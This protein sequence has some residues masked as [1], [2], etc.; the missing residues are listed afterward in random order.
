MMSFPLILLGVLVEW[1][2]RASV[3][4]AIAL[5]GGTGEL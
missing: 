1:F 3:E 2:N 5:S 4:S